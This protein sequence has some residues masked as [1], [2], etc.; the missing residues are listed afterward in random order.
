MSEINIIANLNASSRQINKILA[1]LEKQ[2]LSPKWKKYYFQI[3]QFQE[4]AGKTIYHFQEESARYQRKCL[5]EIPRKK[6][7]GAYSANYSYPI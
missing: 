4:L 2:N 7:N 6:Y 5:E 1:D 3:K